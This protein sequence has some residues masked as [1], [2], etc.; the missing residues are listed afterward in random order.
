MTMRKGDGVGGGS[1]ACYVNCGGGSGGDGSSSATGG[2][3][4]TCCAGDDDGGPGVGGGLG[5][6]N[7]GPFGPILG[8][9]MPVWQVSEPY[10]NLWLYDEPLGYQPGLGPRLSFALTHKQRGAPMVAA[11]IYSVGTNWACSWLSYVEDDG[12]GSQALL[13]SKSGGQLSYAPPNGSA[14]E[15]YTHSTLQRQT[16]SGSLSGFVRVFPSG[17]TDYYQAIPANVRLPNGHT[18]VFLSARTDPFGRTNLLFSYAEQQVNSIWRFRLTSVTD[19]DG[20]VTS[21]SYT[22]SNPAL[23][24]GVADPFGRSAVL[25]YD[26]TGRLTNITDTAGLSSGVAYD[27]QNWIT[28]LATPY[29]ATSFQHVDNGFTNSDGSYNQGIVR[30]IRVIDPAGGTNIYMLRNYCSF[31]TTP[32]TPSVSGPLFDT[33]VTYRDSF[34]WGPRQAASVPA[35]MS[36]FGAADYLK[37]RLRHW[38]YATTNCTSGTV[39]GQA[40]GVQIEPSPDGVSQG[41]ATWYAYDGMGC[42]NYE[43]TNALPAFV[44]RVLPDTTTWYAAYQ[45]DAWGRA[46]NVTGTYSTGYGQAPQLRTRQYLYSGPDLV[47]VIGVQGETLAGYVYTNHLPLRATNAVGEVTSYTWDGQ[48]RLTSIQTAGGLTT[49]NLYFASG[50]YTNFVQ[51]AIDLEISRTNAFT[52]TNDLVYSMT[53]ERG[54]TTTYRYDN[55]G[56]LTNAADA[57]GTASYVYDKLDLVRQVDRLGFSTLYLYDALRRRTAETNALGRATLYDYCAC[58]ALDWVRDAAGNYTYYTYDNAGRR[59]QTAYPDGYTVNNYYDLQGKL[60]L[61]TDS[62]GLWTSNAFNN[63]GQLYEVDDAGGLRSVLA[64][65]AEDRVTNRWDGNGLTIGMTYD[66]LGRLLSR[67]Y[68]D[69]GT[70]DFAYS[71]RGLAAY[72]NQLGYITYYGYDAAGRKVAE[73]N[74][75]NEIIRYTNSPAGDLLSL[76]DGKNQTTTWTYDAYGRVSNKLDQAGSLILSYGYDAN[77]RLTNRWSAAKGNTAYAYDPVGNLTNITYASSGTVKFAYD[78]LNRMTNM[79]DG[80]GTNG[81]TYD[82]VGQLLTEGGVFAS[83]VVTNTYSNRQ[84]VGL[85]LQQPTGAWTNGFGWDGTGR[86]A[87]VTSP[88]GSFGYICTPLYSPFSGRLVQELTLPNGA[89]VTNW[90]DTSARLLGT[91]LKSSGG[92]TLDSALYGYNQGNQRTAYTND[93]LAYYHYGYDSIGQVTVGTSS[94]AS[95]SRGYSYDSAWNLHYLTNNGSLSTFLVDGRNE[96][97]NAFGASYSYDANGNLTAGT[98]SH[99]AYVYDD[100]NR[101]VQWFW[102]ATDSSHLT[103]GAARTDFVYDGLGRLRKRLEYYIQGS[104]GGGGQGPEWLPGPLAQQPS[105]TFNYGVLYLYDGRRVI[106]E[107]DTNNVPLVSYTRG[108]DL[109]GSLEGAGGIGGLLSRSAGYSSGNWTSHAYYHADGNGNI[110]RMVDGS[111]AM[112]ATYRYDPFGNTVSQSGTLA[113]ANVYRFSS[114]E[115]HTNS[116]TYYYGYRFYSLGMQRWISRDPVEE[117]GFQLL[118]RVVRDGWNVANL[119]VFVANNPPNRVDYLGLK[120][121]WQKIEAGWWAFE[122]ALPGDEFVDALKIFGGC[123]SLS[124]AMTWAENQ[125]EADLQEAILSKDDAAQKAAEK[126]WAKKINMMRK[127]YAAQCTPKCKT[128]N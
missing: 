87:S 92:I 106:Q 6:R 1:V 105:W 35:D 93:H 39:L 64:F 74:A 3:G 18:P 16:A 8:R 71:A 7:R 32:S 67:W 25:Q 101:L 50:A 96:L 118:T 47:A 21:L 104:G 17:A 86:L 109:S 55:L 2:E 41:Q 98:N 119:Y 121:W 20:R 11:N 84:R 128:K 9:G 103:N 69:G 14:M 102:Y 66:Y 22:N 49:T 34:H 122:H 115:I 33:Q 70:E 73:T 76:T 51:T 10:I 88:A 13:T 24:T 65:D 114:K 23:I 81:Y 40:L 61:T 42:N 54:L 19:A 123:G 89:Y 91:W 79:V 43:G 116:Q 27:S 72:T 97:T 4:A 56:R 26:S 80:V 57:L 112:V 31:I 125:F 82:A 95:E 126:K 30:S 75:N 12:T 83:D 38:L 110:T 60:I 124:A 44:G 36:T 90:Y 53:D 28:S 78:G 111:Q 59:T 68:P 107:R 52:Y 77:S 120:D 5:G 15:Y 94:T 48:E 37:A 58:G 99:N 45:R 117:L 63:Q 113:D 100:E 127:V 108:N 62:A 46:T 29:G 85:R